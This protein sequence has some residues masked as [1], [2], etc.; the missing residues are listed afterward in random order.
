VAACKNHNFFNLL[1]MCA[2]FALRAAKMLE[3]MTAGITP[4]EQTAALIKLRQ[5][6]NRHLQMIRDHLQAAFITPMD[7]D[8]IYKIAKET[9]D[10]TG[11]ICTAADKL[12]MMNITR[13]NAPVKIMASYIVDA[14]EKLA[15]LMPEIKNH[16]K[17]NRTG[18]KA[19][20]IDE[21]MKMGGKCFKGAVRELFM[22]ERDPIELVKTKEIYEGLKDALLSCGSAADCVRAILATKT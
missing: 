6:A 16:K 15:D 3:E 22:K 13:I 9:D 4:E 20:E 7:R 8:D 10:I 18:G 17:K 21:I 2:G 1:D 11:T 12:W 14:C 19:A 5:D